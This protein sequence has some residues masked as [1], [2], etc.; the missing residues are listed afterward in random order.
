MKASSEEY[1]E[2]DTLEDEDEI[3]ELTGVSNDTCLVAADFD[4]DVV[5][6]QPGGKGEEENID[7]SALRLCMVV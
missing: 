7:G 6:P 5:L 1:E 2:E 3:E 4:H